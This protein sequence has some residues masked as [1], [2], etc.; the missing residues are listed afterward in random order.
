MGI[1]RSNREE[2]S[3]TLETAFLFP[4][5]VA[6][7]VFGSLC[8]RFCVNYLKV[9]QCFYQTA[10]TLSD[11]AYLYH[12]KTISQLTTQ[13]KGAVKEETGDLWEDLFAGVP[14]EM[15]TL[16][17]LEGYLKSY[18][19]DLLDQAES[20]VYVPI[21]WGVF[22]YHL[23]QAGV[24]DMVSVVNFS[25]STFFLNG[26]E[27]LLDLRCEIPFGFSFLHVDS[28]PKHYRL[29]TN[30][31]VTGVGGEVT[32]TNA[33]IWE[34]DNFSRGKKI[35]SMYGGNLPDAFPT[36]SKFQNGRA[37]MIKSVDFRKETYQVKGALSENIITMLETL[38]A[39]QGQ[40][41]PYGKEQIVILPEQIKAKELLLV[42]PAATQS[43]LIQTELAKA[44]AVAEGYSI[45]FTVQ[46]L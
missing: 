34:L 40:S 13:W 30:A 10:E 25:G 9:E 28:I 23:R 24:E 38:A 39:Y 19:S 3:V 43:E 8:I 20:Q 22:Q 17:P 12:E 32:E 36:I 42:I 5:L 33:A 21:A 15:Q 4:V 41:V 45:I 37:T 35:R 14:E 7:L 2:G 46:K 6:V 18:E 11:Y 16:L 1:R 27:I 31:W 29:R 44:S 26:H